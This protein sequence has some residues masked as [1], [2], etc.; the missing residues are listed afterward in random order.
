MNYA[1]N[2]EIRFAMAVL[3]AERRRREAHAMRSLASSRSGAAQDGRIPAAS[4]STIVRSSVSGGRGPKPT[5]FGFAGRVPSRRKR[6]G[7]SRTF[8]D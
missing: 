6:R 7:A 2:D 4:G 1:I 3:E 8:R 5:T